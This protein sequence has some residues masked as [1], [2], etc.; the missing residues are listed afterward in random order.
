[1]IKLQQNSDK[2]ILR[3][4]LNIHLFAVAKTK[5]TYVYVSIDI[6]IFT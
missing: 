2:Q 6:V 1:M 3:S 4:Y 5:Y